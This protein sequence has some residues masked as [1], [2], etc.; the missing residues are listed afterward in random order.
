[1]AAAGGNPWAT[2]SAGSGPVPNCSYQDKRIAPG[3]NPIDGG[4]GVQIVGGVLSYTSTVGP[5]KGKRFSYPVVRPQAYTG[6]PRCVGPAGIGGYWISFSTNP[7]QDRL[8]LIY[9]PGSHAAA[10]GAVEVRSAQTLP[11]AK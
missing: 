9:P 3:V 4:E 10:I 6:D 7:L 2:M 11:G 8:F 1:M 5:N